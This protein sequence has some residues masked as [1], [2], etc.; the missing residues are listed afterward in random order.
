[1]ARRFINAGAFNAVSAGQTATLD[2]SVGNLA[3]HMFQLEYGTGAAGGATQAQMESD[4]TE[5]RIR[6]NGKV[7]RRMSAKQLLAIN[8]WNG[9]AVDA[10]A[11]AGQNGFLPIWLS[12]P[13]RRSAQGEDALAWGTS[14]IQSLQLEVDLAAAANAP[15][16]PDPSAEI[17]RVARGLGGIIKYRKFRVPVSGIGQVQFFPP[18]SDAYARIHAFETAAGDIADVKVTIAGEDVF[19]AT[20]DKIEA[21]YKSYGLVPQAGVFHIA[22][23]RTQRV[24][25]FESLVRNGATVGDFRLDF[26]MAVANSFDLITEVFGPRD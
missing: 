20:D 19:D 26:N 13:W 7:Q 15:K 12:E 11:G 2:L 9:L 22:F 5:I 14:D 25:D 17:E 16:F 6:V 23:D 24:F 21:I 1:M 3:Y 10:G 4:I 8:K 18:R